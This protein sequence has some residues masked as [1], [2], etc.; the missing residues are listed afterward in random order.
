MENKRG[1]LW[2]W[3]TL[4]VQ[5]TWQANSKWTPHVSSIWLSLQREQQV[6]S[7][8]TWVDFNRVLTTVHRFWNH[9]LT[10]SVHRP[11]LKIQTTRFADRIVYCL[12]VKFWPEDGGPIL[13]QKTFSFLIRK[14]SKDHLDIFKCPA[15][16][17]F[18][19]YRPHCR[20]W[21]G[22]VCG[23]FWEKRC[24]ISWFL[25]WTQR[26]L[27]IMTWGHGSYDLIWGSKGPSI[28]PFGAGIF[29][30]HILYIKCE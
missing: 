30:G 1:S 5:T 4:C 14:A 19:P 27:K 17:Y 16:E 11:V 29:F 10:S 21:R 7:C 9:H 3:Q 24:S 6:T 12:Q 28:K 22:L 15:D 25:S 20:I 26:L 18:S 23:D 2:N 13:L 8:V